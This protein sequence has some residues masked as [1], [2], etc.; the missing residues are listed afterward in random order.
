MFGFYFYFLKISFGGWPG[1][2][3]VEFACSTS[4]AQGSQAQILGTDLALL[5]KPGCG[6]VLHKLEEDWQQMLAQ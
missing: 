2:I 3:V 5:V 4:A 6:S 1:G